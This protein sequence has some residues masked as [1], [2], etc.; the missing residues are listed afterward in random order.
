MKTYK[1]RTRSILKKATKKRF[2]ETTIGSAIVGIL[3]VLGLSL[4]PYDT[5][6]PNVERYASSEYYSVIQKMNILN[7][8]P[9]MY[10][11]PLEKFLFSYLPI[12]KNSEGDISIDLGINSGVIGPSSD[13]VI[14]DSEAGS[15]DPGDIDVT[16]NQVAGVIEGDRFKRSDSHIFYIRDGRIVAFTID[17]ENST[18]V[19]YFTILN[20]D[21]NKVTN[22]Q[23]QWEMFISSDYQTLTL[24]SSAYNTDAKKSY[25]TLISIDISDP[26][27]MREKNRTYL[28]GSYLSARMIGDE[29]LVMSNYRVYKNQINFDEPTT[30]I[31]EYGTMGNMQTIDGSNIVAPET[32]SNLAY[33]VVCKVDVATLEAKSTGAF[34][35]Y[36][37]EVYVSKN[38]IYA[39]REYLM[40]EVVEHINID[41]VTYTTKRMT[42]ISALSYSGDS[43]K[44]LGM[45]SVEGEILNQYSM[46]EYEGILRVVTTTTNRNASLYC[47]DLNSWEVVASVENFAPE[48]ETVRSVRYDGTAAYVCTAYTTVVELSDPVYFFDLSDLDNIT[49]KDTG[50]IEG[51]SS[52]LVNFGD[53]LLGIGYGEDWNT[54]KIEIYA[55]TDTV[56]E[57]I[58]SYEVPR[59]EFSEEYKSYLIDRKNMRLGLGYSHRDENGSYEDC[60]VLLQFDGYNLIEVVK[61]PVTGNHD[62]IRAVIIDEYIY[63]FGDNFVVEKL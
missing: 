19:G 3:I 59:C 11:N 23:N 48:G 2:Q 62:Y 42:E 63:I 27:R 51:F 26:T 4:I 56:V 30:Y 8:T 31:P 22:K 60:Y 54:L 20:K 40:N 34:L 1:E 29:L 24:I 21:G 57:S 46:D 17:G 32:L 39:S 61:A 5:T 9:P 10:K 55:E 44:P 25:V 18:E 14:N 45:I 53:V 41:R 28:S 58:C 37:N 52:S 13:G 12:S 33:T 7:Y 36:S 35:S 43:F 47:I 6:P 50:T 15:K 38:N 49:Y 16:D